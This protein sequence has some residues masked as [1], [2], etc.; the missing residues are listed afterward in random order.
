[1]IR[2]R[3]QEDRAAP[4]D[5]PALRFRFAGRAQGDIERVHE[6]GGTRL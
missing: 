4:A 3:P 6:F 2:K 5:E 1:M